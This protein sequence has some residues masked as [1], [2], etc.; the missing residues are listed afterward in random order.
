MTSLLPKNSPFC[1]HLVLREEC[2]LC[3]PLP[4]RRDWWRLQRNKRTLVILIGMWLWISGSVFIY[5]NEG[6]SFL[7]LALPGV[8]L[9]LILLW[10][11]GGKEGA[12]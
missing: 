2:P 6:V 4:T 7:L 1:Q 3:S 9:G 5:E 8:L 10:W 12:A 11:F